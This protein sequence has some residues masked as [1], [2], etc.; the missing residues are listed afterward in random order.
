MDRTDRM[1]THPASSASR[2]L[3]TGHRPGRHRAQKERD[4]RDRDRDWGWGWDCDWEELETVRR[5]VVDSW[6]HRDPVLSMNESSWDV[7]ELVYCPPSLPF[8]QP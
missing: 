4:L 1:S 8:N 5:G 6:A 2:R 3:H 7:V